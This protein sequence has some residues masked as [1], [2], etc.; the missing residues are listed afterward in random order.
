MRERVSTNQEQ[1]IQLVA[2]IGCKQDWVGLR[3]AFNRNFERPPVLF[4]SIP[5]PRAPFSRYVHAHTCSAHSTF[6]CPPSCPGTDGS[7]L[8]SPAHL[9]TITATAVNTTRKKKLQGSRKFRQELGRS[10]QAQ[11]KIDPDTDD[12][13][14]AV[15]QAM[16]LVPEGVLD[17]PVGDPPPCA[18][19]AATA[20]AI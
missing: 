2:F 7:P 20:S 17:E 19:G 14:D 9:L 3:P 11:S 5:L 16:A 12:F 6:P 8:R 18:L 4:R 1:R 10:V 13:R 15:E